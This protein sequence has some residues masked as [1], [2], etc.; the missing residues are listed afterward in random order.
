[1]TLKEK[2]AARRR[3][4]ERRKLNESRKP[5][6]YRMKLTELKKIIRQEAR[7]ARVIKEQEVAGP[8][9]RPRDLP[10]LDIGR[11]RPKEEGGQFYD[12]DEFLDYLRS[13]EKTGRGRPFEFDVEVGDTFY[14]VSDKDLI[15]AWDD[16]G[17]PVDI[18]SPNGELLA[19][20]IV[21]LDVLGLE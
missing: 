14:T 15:D 16:D 2:I 13:G 20:A 4:M 8:V 12:T 1:M 10:G 5:K 6:V 17:T 11:G 3:I 18:Y 19:K 7:R 21:N 9:G